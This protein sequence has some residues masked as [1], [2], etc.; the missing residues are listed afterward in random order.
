MKKSVLSVAPQVPPFLTGSDKRTVVLRAA[1]GLFLRDGYS[2][3]SMDSVTQ[4]AGVSKAT[5]Y[6]HFSSKQKLFEAL[7]R[8]G[9][10]NALTSIPP[11]V[12]SGGNP[13]DE[14]V[15]F[16]EQFLEEVIGRGAFA[17]NRLVIAEAVRHPENATLF[18]QC[19]FERVTKLV[20]TYLGVLSREGWIETSSLRLAAEALLATT[21]L[22][23]LHRALVL[24]AAAVDYRASLRFSVTL[25]LRGVAPA[26]R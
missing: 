9:S 17:W 21:L 15:A 10:E 3:T 20:E 14:I 22:G 18:Y 24:G 26:G 5:V 2:A 6:A 7:V 23:H 19:T 12:R 13:V 1:H 4:E 16:F 11:L 25:F 8:E